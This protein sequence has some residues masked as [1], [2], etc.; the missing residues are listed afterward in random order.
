MKMPD[1]IIKLLKIDESNDFIKK[2]PDTKYTQ[3]TDIY[4]AIYNDKY[5]GGVVVNKNPD[6]KY[7]RKKGLYP[8]VAIS[9]LF[10][11]N[12][13]RDY[14]LGQKLLNI[15][16]KKYDKICLTTNRNWTNEAA[17]HL[18]EKNGFKIIKDNKVTSLWYWER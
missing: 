12:K 2:F 13:Y 15:V 5:I 10:I 6:I 14:G 4:A 11:K 1:F 3:F 17:I 7:Y 16:N 9:Y 8:K 18:Y